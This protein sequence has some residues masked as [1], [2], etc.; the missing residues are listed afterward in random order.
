M[1]AGLPLP[2]EVPEPDGW[3]GNTINGVRLEWW[4]AD[5]FL[6]QL[7]LHGLRYGTWYTAAET[8][9]RLSVS[10]ETVLACM[11]ECG[12]FPHATYWKGQWWFPLEDVLHV[13]SYR[14]P[15]I[16]EIEEDWYCTP[17]EAELEN[18]LEVEEDLYVPVPM[19]EQE[20]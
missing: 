10:E 1:R 6:S 2:F 14:W 15:P 5:L 12:L 19:A 9:W 7:D 18:G 8:A 16:I 3:V 17:Y 11:W 4:D 20:E 13:F